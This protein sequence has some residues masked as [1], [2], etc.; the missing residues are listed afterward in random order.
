MSNIF[1]RKLLYIA[2]VLITFTAEAS[3]FTLMPDTIRAEDINRDSITI[4]SINNKDVI[5]S[6]K[7]FSEKDNFFSRLLKHVLVADVDDPRSSSSSG[8]QYRKYA[9]KIIR[10]IDVRV[11]D[12]FGTSVDHPNDT[13]QSW[14]QQTGNAVHLNTR[15]WLIKDRLLFTEGGTLFPFELAE[16]ERLLRQNDFIYDAK[17]LVRSVK[18]VSDSVDVIVLVQDVWSITGGAS[19]QP[20]AKTGKVSL[21]DINFLG[22]GNEINGTVKFDDVYKSGWDWDGS[23][24]FSNI[25]RTYITGTLFHFSERFN[26]RYG[27]NFNRDFFSPVTRYAGGM[28]MQWSSDKIAVLNDT[29]HTI[30]D[31]RFNRQDYWLGYAFDLKPFDPYSV[32]FNRFNLSLRLTRTQYTQ[33]PP[34][35]PLR[36]FQNNTFYLA[37]L[38]YSFRTY[39]RD[40]YL[41]GLGKI[42]DI[43]LGSLAE[44]LMGIE[45]GQYAD[46]PYLGF[47]TGY[48]NYSDSFGYLYGGFQ[49][50]GYRQKSKWTNGVMILESLFYSKLL[51][52]GKLKWRH[53]LGTRYSYSYNP[54]IAEDLL[55]INGDMGLRGFDTEERGN[56]KLVLNY[57]NDI[58]V[59]LKFLNF[60]LAFITFADFALLAGKDETLF[61]SKLYQGYGIGFRIRN[62]HLVFPT[63]QLML[64]F[65]PNDGIK[66]GNR[67]EVFRQQSMFYHFNQFQISAPSVVQF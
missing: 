54:V 58:F 61:Q 23:Y 12:V 35:D 55:N 17:I 50:G 31:L 29:T 34:M 10:N 21:R 20:Q 6:V 40:R 33:A 30:R 52:I 36:A 41:F 13:A 62:E 65:Y 37:R 57:E 32:N 2:F 5:E 42:E 38:G 8:E 4:S 44:L 3:A 63:F 49:M 48:S 16:S 53:Y 66:G 19:Y 47:K 18:N 7:K 25:D 15:S 67:F 59:P 45:R 56:K 27:F 26:Q 51:P 22:L 24:T 11:L 1:F 39:Y 46:R 60:K 43:P 28:G 14:L 64:G 9:G